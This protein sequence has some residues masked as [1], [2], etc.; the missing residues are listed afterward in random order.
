MASILQDILLSC[1]FLTVIHNLNVRVE[2]PNTVAVTFPSGATRL[3]ISDTSASA[4]SADNKVAYEPN[5]AD[6][7]NSRL[8]ALFLNLDAIFPCIRSLAAKP[9]LH[10]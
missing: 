2:G 1:V 10:A 6:H 7:H 3:T 4:K 8:G 9:R 5:Y